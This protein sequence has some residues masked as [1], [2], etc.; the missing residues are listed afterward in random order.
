MTRDELVQRGIL[1]EADFQELS[2]LKFGGSG[3]AL[4]DDSESNERED[5]SKS[6]GEFKALRP[7]P[8]KSKACQNQKCQK[9]LGM[10][11]KV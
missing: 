8:S 3:Q 7:T 4:V 6:K 11:N 1:T 2:G 10:G 9:K 5:S